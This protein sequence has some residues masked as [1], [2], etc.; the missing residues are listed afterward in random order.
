MLGGDVIL[1]CTFKKIIKYQENE[2]NLIYY[3]FG[4]TT[5]SL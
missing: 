3:S 4:D 5:G 1:Y 2:K